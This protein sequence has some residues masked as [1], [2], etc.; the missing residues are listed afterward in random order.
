MVS[1]MTVNG[2]SQHYAFTHTH[3]HTTSTTEYS[4]YWMLSFEADQSTCSVTH[5]Y[6]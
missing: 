6:V 4:M 2:G 3:T 5:K 1:K